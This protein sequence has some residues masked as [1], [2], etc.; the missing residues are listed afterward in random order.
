VTDCEHPEHREFDFWVGEWE[1]RGP[2]DKVAGHNR[3]SKV[4]GG[5]A[6]L[7]EWQSVSD[8]SGKS[9]NTWSSERGVWHQTWVDSAG[10]LLI[11][12]GGM[13]DSVIIMEG[14]TFDSERPG[15]TVHNRISWSVL[16]ES[17][18]RLR[19]HWETSTDGEHWETA[20]DGYY[21]R[22]KSEPIA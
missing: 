5:C 1:V 18:D 3:I 2:K 10:T 12:E 15:E 8:F 22:L 9:L 7:E 19:Q 17:G 13:R 16:D 11:I 4:A 20:F 21:T 14:T 6:L